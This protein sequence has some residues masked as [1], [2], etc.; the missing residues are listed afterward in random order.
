MASRKRRAAD[1][2]E[3]NPDKK[4]AKARTQK[5]V[6]DEE[7]ARKLIAAGRGEYRNLQS[8]F[9]HSPLM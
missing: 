3:P 1:E 5:L 8:Q 4:R 2:D 6:R 9:D 7:E